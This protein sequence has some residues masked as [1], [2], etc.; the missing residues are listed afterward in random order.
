MCYITNIKFESY[1]IE[2]IKI[3]FTRPH[4]NRVYL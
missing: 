1:F 2:E 4:L 3:T